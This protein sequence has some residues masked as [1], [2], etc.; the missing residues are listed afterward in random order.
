MAAMESKIEL[1]SLNCLSSA[2]SLVGAGGRALSRRGPFGAKRFGELMTSPGEKIVA[3]IPCERCASPG[4]GAHAVIREIDPRLGG[5]GAPRSGPGF[6]RASESRVGHCVPFA[7]AGRAAL[8]RADAEKLG[9]AEPPPTSAARP[10][11]WEARGT[12][13]LDGRLREFAG[14]VLAAG[15]DVLRVHGLGDY[16]KQW[17]RHEFPADAL[18]E[19]ERAVAATRRG[20]SR[21]VCPS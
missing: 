1:S 14:A 17:V 12:I 11:R 10:S 16:R 3:R 2:Q 19:L 13:L 9:T 4:L 18:E 5:S 8:S 7:G 20:A 15:Q 21:G 6:R